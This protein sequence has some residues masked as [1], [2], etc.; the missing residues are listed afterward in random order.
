MPYIYEHNEWPNFRYDDSILLPIL[1]EIELLHQRT[2]I[3]LD[4]IGDNRKLL[5]ESEAIVTEIIMNFGIEDVRLKL[6]KSNSEW[7]FV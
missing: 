3:I 7:Q 1:S 6:P 2:K 4:F 5:Y